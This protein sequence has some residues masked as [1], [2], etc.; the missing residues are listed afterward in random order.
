MKIKTTNEPHF[1]DT[2]IS[3]YLDVV[4]KEYEIELQ[5]KSSFESRS[6]MIMAFIGTI[7]VFF[8]EKINLSTIDFSFNEPLSLLSLIKFISLSLIY[9]SLVATFVSSVK[10]I[11]TRKLEN[12]DV[13]KIDIELLSET[14]ST[15]CARIIFTY[16]SIISNCRSTNQAKE[17]WY[18]CSLIFVFIL[19]LSIFAYTNI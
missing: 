1:E 4:K 19:F 6:G 15:A 2:A 14:R 17:K 10:T 8:F 12:F 9:F 18:R 3:E 16:E 13:E 7:Y 11:S 5:K